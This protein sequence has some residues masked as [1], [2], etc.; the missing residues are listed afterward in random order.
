MRLGV[1]GVG[2]T[3]ANEPMITCLIERGNWA[4]AP[5]RATR[6]QRWS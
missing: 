2:G 3:E 4:T 1:E 5:P 6:Q